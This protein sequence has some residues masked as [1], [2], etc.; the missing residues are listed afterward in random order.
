MV[1]CDNRSNTCRLYAV[2]HSGK[3]VERQTVYL[4]DEEWLSGISHRFGKVE[5]RYVI[6]RGKT[7][8]F[9]VIQYHSAEEYLNALGNN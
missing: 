3:I 1:V 5:D 8:S 2:K 4:R 6:Y 7:Q 9:G